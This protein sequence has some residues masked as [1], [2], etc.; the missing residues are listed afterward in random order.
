MEM[1]ESEAEIQQILVSGDLSRGLYKEDR[2][3]G[4]LLVR[5]TQG[6]DTAYIYD[7][8]ILPEYQRRGL[9]TA[10]AREA[11][12]QARSRGLKVS[13]HARSTGYPLFGNRGRM[14]EMGY[15]VTMDELKPDWYFAEYG[16]HEDARE[17]L[18]EP[19]GAFTSTEKSSS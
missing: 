16:V 13:L 19:V 7:I 1:R 2:L 9:G 12:S 14:R 15:L 3:V 5:W 17:L 11:L 18:L 8:A 10:L 4:Y 6:A